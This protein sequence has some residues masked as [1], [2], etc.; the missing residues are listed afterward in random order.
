MFDGLKDWVSPPPRDV[1]IVFLH[2]AKCGGTS[3]RRAMAECFKPWRSTQRDSVL[4]LDEMAVREAAASG[5]V[6]HSE[7][8]RAL[9]AYHLATT[10]AGLVAGHYRYSRS[11]FERYRAAWSFITI[12]RHPVDRWYSNYFFNASR[13]EGNIYRIDLP[14]EEFIRTER[15]T[16]LGTELVRSFADLDDPAAAVEED[17][18]A[19]AI[20]N[21]RDLS[22]VG[23][24]ED[25]PSFTRFFSESFGCSLDIPTLN[26]TPSDGPKPRAGVDPGVAERVRELCLPDLA[27][28]K[29]FF[30][31]IA[32]RDD[33]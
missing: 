3:I 17:A 14:I 19:R 11:V 16:L 29:A 27:V 15:A 24:L 22:F 6:H 32:D 33:A 28:Y 20:E 25:L 4:E 13:P 23:T 2:I 12:L 9:L 30:P 26:R 31:E 18:A 1:R 10:N 8:R 7:A 5:R 21:L